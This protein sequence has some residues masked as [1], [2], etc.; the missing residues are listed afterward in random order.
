MFSRYCSQP[1]T[2]EQVEVKYEESNEVKVTP[3]SS[4]PEMDTDIAYVNKLLGTKF[5]MKGIL[6]LK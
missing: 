1:F 5:G 3:D 6:V 2:F 4:Y